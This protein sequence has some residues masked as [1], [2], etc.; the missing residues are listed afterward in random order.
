MKPDEVYENEIRDED[1]TDWFRQMIAVLLDRLGEPFSVT[2]T[3]AQ[4]ESMV[5]RRL[6]GEVFSEGGDRIHLTLLP[7]K[8]GE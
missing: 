5:G 3:D 2:I 6:R 7:K 1:G 4:L 8:E